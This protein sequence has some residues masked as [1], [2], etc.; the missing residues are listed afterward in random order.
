MVAPDLLR[1]RRWRR[2]R[3]EAGG[4]EEMCKLINEEPGQPACKALAASLYAFKA[5]VKD[6]VLRMVFA[7]DLAAALN[8][9]KLL[10]TDNYVGFLEKAYEYFEI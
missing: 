10:P 7:Q 2:D 3:I 8:R 5:V 1:I 6:P 9:R 4:E